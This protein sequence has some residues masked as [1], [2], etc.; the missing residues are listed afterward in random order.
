MN[1]RLEKAGEN[2]DFRIRVKIS[3]DQQLNNVGIY[4]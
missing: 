3:N 2:F 1:D 4:R